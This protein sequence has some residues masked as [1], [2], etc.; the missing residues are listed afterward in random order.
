MTEN[1]WMR[2]DLIY[3][4]SYIWPHI[5]DL[6]NLHVDMLQRNDITYS[7]TEIKTTL[8]NPSNPLNLLQ[9]ILA[10]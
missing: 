2:F 9:R 5:F 4:T 7:S 1:E 8:C 6:M 3:L 10:F